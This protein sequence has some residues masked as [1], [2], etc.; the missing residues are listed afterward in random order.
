MY[1]S[2]FISTF[3][4]YPFCTE[5][6]QSLLI[7]I[8][9]HFPLEIL[10]LVE[11]VKIEILK[12][13]QVR[14]LTAWQFVNVT[15]GIWHAACQCREI[16]FLFG[17]WVGVV[18]FFN[19]FENDTKISPFFILSV[20]KSYC[21]LSIDHRHVMVSIFYIIAVSDGRF[22]VR[23]K[24]KTNSKMREMSWC[25]SFFSFFKKYKIE[26]LEMMCIL[27]PSDRSLINHLM[28]SINSNGW[29]IYFLKKV[30]SVYLSV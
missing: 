2:M 14:I 30:V 7:L 24:S 20:K 9:L 1:H 5:A 10:V 26:N 15:T 16:P 22:D 18:I 4:C 11:F 8:N 23:I 21:I 17:G 27:N 12:N 13:K 19:L 29:S 3:L 25:I 28:I 6:H